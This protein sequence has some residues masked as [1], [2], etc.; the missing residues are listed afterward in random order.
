MAVS[1]ERYTS[2][3]VL[4]STNPTGNASAWTVT[5]LDESL[6]LRGVS[7]A[8]TA[9]CVAG[10]AGGN[11]L[12]STSPTVASAWREA[13]G[14]KG[15]RKVKRPKVTIAKLKLP[16]RRELREHRANAIVRFHANGPVRRIECKVDR[17]RF[18]RCLV[19]GE[20]P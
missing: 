18:H 2:G 7:C 17:R 4:T 12:T 19:G 20:L 10:N 14:G 1:G 6:D 8:A 11:L 5:Q 16:S 15:K 13:D 9:L 3:K